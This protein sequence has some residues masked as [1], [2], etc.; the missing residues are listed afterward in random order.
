V[1]ALAESWEANDTADQWTIHIH[2]DATWSDGEPVTAEDVRWTY[3]TCLHPDTGC[4]MLR[5]TQLLQIAGAQEY[6]EGA[7]DGISGIEVVDEKTVQFT[8]NAP[9]AT[10]INELW[11]GIVPQHALADV[12]KTELQ[13]HPFNA[14]GPTVVSG[15]LK[16]VGRQGDEYYEL[17]RNEN[18]WGETASAFDTVIMKVLNDDVAAAQLEAGEIE[19]GRIP[20][21]EA[22]RLATLPHLEVVFSPGDLVYYWIVNTK[23]PF[24]QDARVRQA[25]MY[26]MNRPDVL[27]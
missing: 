2:P 17:A 13:T 11:Q 5:H 27:Q 7:A 4:T 8:L 26:A 25:L 23:K 6:S 15:P 19:F 24:L 18:Y 16:F 14:D 3:E 21:G 9:N 12:A 1:P 10:F 22:A 20:A